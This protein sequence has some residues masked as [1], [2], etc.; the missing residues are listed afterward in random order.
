MEFSP[1]YLPGFLISTTVARSKPLAYISNASLS[2]PIASDWV[3]ISTVSFD[4]G[5]GE[6]SAGGAQQSTAPS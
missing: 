4:Q 3:E 5:D 2:Q 6:E 1:A